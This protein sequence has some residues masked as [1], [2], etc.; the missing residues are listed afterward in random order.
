MADKFETLKNN[1]TCTDCGGNNMT[2]GYGTSEGGIYKASSFL[3][4]AV[5]GHAT[6]RISIICGDCGLI[7]KEYA[8]DPAKMK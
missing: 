5:Y 7:V 3:G 2:L 4:L 1:T 6:D 8:K